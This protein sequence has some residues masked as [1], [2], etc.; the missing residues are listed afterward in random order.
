MIRVLVA[1]DHHL[2][3]Q[4]IRALL[5]RASDI[6]IVGEACDGQ[7]AVEL[8]VRLKPDVILMDLAMPRLNGSL[9]TERI[10]SLHLPSQVVIL[11]MYSNVEWVREALRSGAR[12][13]LLKHAVTEELLL[14]IRAAQRGETFLSPQISEAALTDSQ[15]SEQEV[16]RLADSLTTREK[17]VLKLAA[18]GKKNHEI[19]AL[20]SLSTKTVEKHR[21]SIMTKLQVHDRAGLVRLAMKLGLVSMD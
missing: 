16:T 21:A 12:G 14:A 6:E 18:E 5:E 8:A 17:E 9:A 1:E 7:E 13:Y 19:A 10:R 3:R 20:L 2:V 4:G 11:S 15:G